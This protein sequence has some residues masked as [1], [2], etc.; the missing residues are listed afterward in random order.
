MVGI[1]AG[2]E[3]GGIGTD[4]LIAHARVC[5]GKRKGTSLVYPISYLTGRSETL[6]S[7]TKG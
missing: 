5:N 2:K 1:F 6:A 3:V 7:E 4:Q